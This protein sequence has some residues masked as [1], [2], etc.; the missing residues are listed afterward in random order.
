VGRPMN[1][2]DLPVDAE[3]PGLLPIAPFRQWLTDRQRHAAATSDDPNAYL[4]IKLGVGVDTLGRWLWSTQQHIGLDRVDRCLCRWGDPGLLRDLYPD[5]YAFPD[6]DE[7]QERIEFLRHLRHTE[8]L[9]WRA[10]TLR[11]KARYGIELEEW[12]ARH[13]IASTVPP[14]RMHS[15]TLRRLGVAA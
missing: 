11:F 4:S 9:K 1:T 3:R 8:R 10:V 12:H 15:Q 7:A 6:L 14:Q 13:L 5:L 2:V